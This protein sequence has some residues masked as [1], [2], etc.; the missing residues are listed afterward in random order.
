MALPATD[1]GA[2][3]LAMTRSRSRVAAILA[4]ALAI[5]VG[6]T[7][8]GPS[9]TPLPSVPPSATTLDPVAIA[10]RIT[11][12]SLATTLDALAE[13]AVQNGGTRRTGSAGDLATAD[14]LEKILAALGLSVA[15]EAF[16][17]PVFLD[18]TADALEVLGP[19]ARAFEADRD[20]GPLM[21]SAPGTVT[22]PVADLGWDPDARAA[23]GRGCERSDFAAV[24]AGEIVLVRPGPCF[25]RTV[26]ENAA[27]AGAVAVVSATPWFDAGAVTRGTLL[28]VVP[29]PAF[30]AAREV[31]DVLAGAAA[32]GAQ[33]RL[34]SSGT[35]ER[36]T[37]RSVI[38]ELRGRDP[39]RVVVVGAHLDSSMD[40]PGIDDN[41]SGVAGVLALARA[42]AGTTP[43]MTVRFAFWA[44]EESGLKGSTEYVQRHA[45]LSSERTIAYLNVDMI[46]SPNGFPVVY[47]DSSA[48]PGS[49]RIRDLFTAD[50]AA[51]GLQWEGWDVSG[52]A[53]HTPFAMSG[54]PTGGLFSGAGEIVTPAQASTFGRTAGRAAD[55]CYHLAC[56]G[57]DN[58]D[59]DLMLDLARSLAR[60]TVQL[61]SDQE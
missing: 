39:S 38:G 46:G 45:P 44:A 14:Y 54:V 16:E 11:P 29:I 7:G 49:D 9:P 4:L 3:G 51:A 1:A 20:F 13:I 42:L 6:G 10:A 53:D 33:V 17:T 25:R 40:G 61:I 22:G 43:A 48:A 27:A 56:D 41:G 30:A 34:V 21:F 2:H 58:V 31:G 35:T 52:S 59:P 36:R 50:L 15:E 32:S 28:D 19:T 8:C 23:D 55:P 47:D 26:V 37:V 60:V 12:Q 5:A 24:T 18:G 57:R